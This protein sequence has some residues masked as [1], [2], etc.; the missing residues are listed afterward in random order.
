MSVTHYGQVNCKDLFFANDAATA[1][2]ELSG[3][4]Y[5]PDQILS[6]DTVDELIAKSKALGRLCFLVSE[7]LAKKTHERFASRG[8][9]FV[10]WPEEAPRRP[11]S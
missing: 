6:A 11:T 10:P 5:Q 4:G 1:V 7:D 3:L 8:L 2:V 9:R